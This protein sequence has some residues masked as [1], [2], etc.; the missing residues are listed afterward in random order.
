MKRVSG[1]DTCF[2]LFCLLVGWGFFD[3][4]KMWMANSLKTTKMSI[5]KEKLS[6]KVETL[7]DI[8]RNISRSLVKPC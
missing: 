7:L 2:V 3:C 4:A 6:F 1:L 8:S 5:T